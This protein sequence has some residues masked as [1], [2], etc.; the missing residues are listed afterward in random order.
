M[1][2]D[3]GI[4]YVCE[5]CVHVCMCVCDVHLYNEIIIMI[6]NSCTV[7]QSH[8]LVSLLY[9]IITNNNTNGKIITCTLKNKTMCDINATHQ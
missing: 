1:Y 8:G 4:A 5:V 2:D 6:I 7:A 9:Y 3:D